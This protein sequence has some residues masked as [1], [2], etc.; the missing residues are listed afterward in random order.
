MPQASV[1]QRNRGAR[2]HLRGRRPVRELDVHPVRQA[3]P[4]QRVLSIAADGSDCPDWV[5]GELWFSRRGIARGYRGR[6]ELTDD[7]E[8]AGMDS[9]DVL[10]EL[11]GG[12]LA[13]PKWTNGRESVRRFRHFVD[14][15][16]GMILTEL[17]G[18]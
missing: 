1:A 13:P 5:P 15:G 3:R 18:G 10:S 7:L 14:L 4:E 2:H 8:I 12:C 17:A 6:A 16:E 11:A 9:A